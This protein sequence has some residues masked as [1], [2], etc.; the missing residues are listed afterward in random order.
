MNKKSTKIS[1]FEEDLKKIQ[2][3]LKDI[4]SDNLTLENSIKKYEEGMKLSKKCQDALDEA[5]QVLKVLD[6]EK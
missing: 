5:K 3:I 4:E 6:D 1:N 2:D